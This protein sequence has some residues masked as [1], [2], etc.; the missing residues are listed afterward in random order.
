MASPSL[1]HRFQ[2]SFVGVSLGSSGL[3]ST[4][5]WADRLRPVS[6]WLL[7]PQPISAPPMTIV[8]AIDTLPLW[9][10]SHENW[11]HRHQWLQKLDLPVSDLA[12]HWAL[13]EAIALILKHHPADS[14]LPETLL[15]RWQAHA[16]NG[17]PPCPKPWQIG[18][19][20]LR[21]HN[22]LAQLLPWLSDQSP[23]Q[24]PLLGGLYLLLTIC[25]S[26]ASAIARAHK[27]PHP[28]SLPFTGA[29]IG[30]YLGLP[31]LPTHSSPA[32]AQ[33]AS[34]LFQDWAG[35]TPQARQNVGD[36]RLH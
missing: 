33:P 26:P 5:A 27:L 17:A 19:T 12:H 16:R 20:Q 2:G 32:L 8:N 1:L 23:D 31:R 21:L 18:L 15:D 24:Q 22:S 11:Y 25:G 34:H 30:A 29:L 3:E 6:Q 35:F 10:Y 14:S 36:P 28:A 13:G 9:L 7:N 4:I